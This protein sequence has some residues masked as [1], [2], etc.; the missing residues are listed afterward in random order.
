MSAR[1]VV[2]VV[3]KLLALT[4]RTLVRLARLHWRRADRG[5][6]IHLNRTHYAA[7]AAIQGDP[8]L[9]RPRIRILIAKVGTALALYHLARAIRRALMTVEGRRGDYWRKR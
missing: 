4:G 6:V 5:L 7:S 8:W 1:L 2:P 3:D 9:R